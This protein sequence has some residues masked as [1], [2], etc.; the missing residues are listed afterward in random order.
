MRREAQPV[1][2]PPGHRSDG[3]NAANLVR[4]GAVLPVF[5]LRGCDSGMGTPRAWLA[6]VAWEIRSLGNPLRASSA[7]RGGGSRPEG[8]TP[9]LSSPSSQWARE[10]PLEEFH[11]LP[12]LSRYVSVLV[13]TQKRL[14]GRCKP[15]QGD[16]GDWMMSLCGG[17]GGACRYVDEAFEVTVPDSIPATTGLYQ[18][19]VTDGD[20]QSAG[21]CSSAFT[22]VDTDED[23]GDDA[24][25]HPPS[26]GVSTPLGGC[27]VSAGDLVRLEVSLLDTRQAEPRR[28][29]RLL[30]AAA[31]AVRAWSEGG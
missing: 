5:D 18:V 20:G 9:R 15:V 13:G 29:G 6:R 8:P 11:S 22:L 3:A 2:S 4:A 26:L 30:A 23:S 31:A 24:R 19:R 17:H 25:P 27:Q 12:T 21:S 1:S 10:L 7:E 16:C 14:G 28:E